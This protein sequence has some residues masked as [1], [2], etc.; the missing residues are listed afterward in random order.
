M[1]NAGVG[2]A[3]LAVATL[4]V[5][6]AGVKMGSGPRITKLEGAVLVVVITLPPLRERRERLQGRP[7]PGA[8][9]VDEVRCRAVAEIEQP[10]FAFD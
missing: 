10:G 3:G 2:L 9:N 4:R 1:L 8:E 6:R 5:M 7:V